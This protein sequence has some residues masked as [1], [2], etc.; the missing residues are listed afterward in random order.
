M[1]APPQEQGWPGS[2][3]ADLTFYQVHWWSVRTAHLRGGGWV[4]GLLYLSRE[5]LWSSGRTAAVKGQVEKKQ[6]TKT[7]RGTGT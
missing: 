5:E 2:P 7:S 3:P 4:R 6:L 1:P